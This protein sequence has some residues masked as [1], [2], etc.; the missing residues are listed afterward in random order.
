MHL[1]SSPHGVR[2]SMR[3]SS[4]QAECAERPMA[5]PRVAGKFLRCGSEKFYVKG[6]SYGPF[7]PNS[8]GEALPERAQVQRDFAHIR[9]LGANTIRV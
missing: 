6:F 7:A 4:P 2:L 3:A 8:D 9:D 1:P 5:R